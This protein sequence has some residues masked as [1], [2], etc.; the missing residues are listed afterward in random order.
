MFCCIIFSALIFCTADGYYNKYNIQAEK[1]ML[2]IKGSSLIKD[3]SL[4]A[5]C[6]VV[7]GKAGFDK[8]WHILFVLCCKPYL[9]IYNT[10]RQKKELTCPSCSLIWKSK[11]T[12]CFVFCLMYKYLYSYHRITNLFNSFQWKKKKKKII[13]RTTH[14]DP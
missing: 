9:E 1:L 5:F 4:F 6:V 2:R 7:L 8:F 3:F 14:V 11:V 13:E 12:F 10:M